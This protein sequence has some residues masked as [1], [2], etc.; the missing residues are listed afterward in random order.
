MT[1]DSIFLDWP[2]QL[3]WMVARL[4]RY[5]RQD[6][7]IT[8]TDAGPPQ[9]RPRSTPY[10]CFGGLVEMDGDTWGMLETLARDVGRRALRVRAPDT[11]EECLATFTTD[12]AGIQTPFA[13]QRV[14]TPGRA[15]RVT[16]RIDLQVHS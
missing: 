10:P 16:A 9:R 13:K 4:E 6:M 15:E 12:D 2:E 3:A 11:N 1:D 5:P 8:P 7:I 14:I